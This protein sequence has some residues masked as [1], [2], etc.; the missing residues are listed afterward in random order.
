MNN[1]IHLLMK[2]REEPISLVMKRISS[3]YVYWYNMKYQRCGHLFQDR[4]KSK[5]VEDRAYF[6][7]ILRYIHQNPLKASLS[8][9]VFD[10]NWTSIHEY[11]YKSIIVDIDFALNQ[12]SPDRNKALECF[13]AHMQILSNDLCLEEKVIVRL[14]DSEVT[15][16]MSEL[17][18]SNS[19]ILQ[20]MDK[21][22]RNDILRKLKKLD[23]VSL[24]Q[25]SR[26]TGVSKSVIQRLN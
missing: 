21:E 16:Y 18:V 12:F 13:K 4:F 24:R 8:Q 23:G 20:Q 9:T 25:L 14:P 10:S 2:E 6:L 17:G 1:H 19:S 3:S 7:T 11:I 26:I 15:N 5:N 22:Q